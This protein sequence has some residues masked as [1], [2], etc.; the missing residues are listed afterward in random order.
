MDQEMTTPNWYAEVRNDFGLEQV[1]A[2]S[3]TNSLAC[4][5]R[6]SEAGGE[7]LHRSLSKLAT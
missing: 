1:R 7:S 2:T 4:G 6:K 5:V 3:W